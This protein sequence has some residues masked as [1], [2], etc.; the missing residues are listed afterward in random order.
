MSV[1]VKP[2]LYSDEIH[3]LA[4]A[5]YAWCAEHNIKLTSQAGLSAASKAIDLFHAGFHNHDVLL[6]AL[7]GD[8]LH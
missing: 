5:L 6:G 4:S 3:V 7:H 1:T 2:Y 8:D